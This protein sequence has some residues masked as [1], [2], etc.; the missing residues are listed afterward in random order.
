MESLINQI[1]SQT[2]SIFQE[3]VSLR[4]HF[5][6]YPELSFEEKKTSEKI[7]EVLS[8]H[9]IG[10]TTGWAKHG[11][12]GTIEGKNPASR[13]IA[14]RA[15]MDAL[16]I[17]ENSDADY[18]STHPGI[19][20]ACGHDVHMTNLIGALIILNTLRDSFEGTVKFIF[21]PAEEKL[22]GGASILIQEGVLENPKP[23][24]MLGLHVQPGMP[25]GQIGLT[26]G[27]FMA[28]CDEIYMRIIGKGGHAAQS[29]FC[30]DP[31]FISSQL[32][33]ALQ[34]L[35][36]REK[37]ASTPSVLSFGKIQSLGGSTNIIP[38]EVYLEGTFRSL[39]ESW[40]QH[41][42]NRIEELSKRL[43]ESFNGSCILDIKRGYPCL[44]ND[45]IKT[46]Q[47][48][49][50]AADYLQTKNVVYLEPR[51]TSED[52]AYY[53][54][55]LPSVF[56]RLGVGNGPGVHTSN[57]DIDENAIKIGSGVLAYLAVKMSK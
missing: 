21:Q 45:P 11:I 52:F 5:H 57:F 55:Q 35:I 36:S 19:M 43:V 47:L 46:Q 38:D 24:C 42:L 4:R 28:S 22:P 56:F 41:A 32:I 1:K 2:D 31:V 44:I 51:L 40:R 18:C 30:I 34:S 20:H 14:L 49:E 17:H 48:I 54:H 7:Q 53:S 8:K 6:K 3:L 33:T 39:D 13:T 29:Q 16:P 50:N 12:V 10:Y 25:V 9:K 15:D 23:D 27:P 26:H 37:P